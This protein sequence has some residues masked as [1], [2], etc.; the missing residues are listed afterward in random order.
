MSIARCFDTVDRSA[1]TSSAKSQ[2]HV[3]PS[4]SASTIRKQLGLPRALAILGRTSRCHYRR[5]PHDT[6][7][8]IEC[9]PGRS[10]RH[11]PEIRPIRRRMRHSPDTC[12]QQQHLRTRLVRTRLAK[13]ARLESRWRGVTQ[14][15]QPTPEIIRRGFVICFTSDWFRRRLGSRSGHTWAMSDERRCRPRRRRPRTM[16]QPVALKCFTDAP[17][18]NLANGRPARHLARATGLPCTGLLVH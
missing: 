3:S 14:S 6:G 2:T 7:P 9:P 18:G 1:P 13:R 5:P 4:A 8:I 16:A 15:R 10:M 12:F 17:R 11:S